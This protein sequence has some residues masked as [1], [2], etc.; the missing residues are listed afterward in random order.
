MY[1]TNILTNKEFWH[2]SIKIHLPRALRVNTKSWSTCWLLCLL[3]CKVLRQLKLNLHRSERHASK[4]NIS[5]KIRSFRKQIDPNARMGFLLCFR[6]VK[7]SHRQSVINWTGRWLG[8]ENLSYNYY[9]LR[10]KRLIAIWL[11]L[12]KKNYNRFLQEF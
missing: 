10:E 11:L 8:Q 3:L 2:L 6:N 4:E 1:F 5:D 7:F 9:N 12:F